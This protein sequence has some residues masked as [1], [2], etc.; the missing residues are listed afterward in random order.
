MSLI[1]S[2][3]LSILLV[4]VGVLVWQKWI[5]RRFGEE[6]DDCEQEET[7][8]FK[9]DVPKGPIS[10][11]IVGNLIQLGDRP[12]EKMMRWAKTYGPIYQLYLGSQRVVVLNGAKLVREALVDQSET[13]AGRPKLY[14]IHATLKGSDTFICCLRVV[15]H[16][17]DCELNVSYECKLERKGLDL[18]AVQ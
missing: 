6:T 15:D 4:L 16:E 7:S 18:V 10:F 9:L 5:S 8:G 3:L 1:G 13:F 12:H 14:M 11:P 2:I 17:F